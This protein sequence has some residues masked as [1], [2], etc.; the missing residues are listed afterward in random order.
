MRTRVALCVDDFGL[1]PCVNEAVVR[2]A[3]AGVVTT[4][5]CMSTGPAWASGAT[6]LQGA[7]RERL[8][9]GLHL[10][11][12]DPMPDGGGD[13]VMPLPELIVRSLLRTLPAQQLRQTI[14]HQLDRFE[15]G[16]GEPP[17]FIDGHQHVHQMP[18]IRDALM[19][20]IDAR[21]ATRGARW[22]PWLRLTAAPRGG[23]GPG[24][25]HRV[26]ESLGARE[27][28]RMARQRGLGLNRSLLGVYGFDEDAQSF[29]SR[30]V[31]WLAQAQDGDLLMLHPA[32]P[33]SDVASPS[34][35]HPQEGVVGDAIA[36][37]REVEYGV[38]A[39]EGRQ[40]LEQHD[41]LPV[42]LSRGSGI[43]DH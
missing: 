17:D 19:N 31:Q 20:A 3:D 27:L 39:R 29:R 33:T 5:G 42:R 38:L 23:S 35:G 37:A 11:L 13:L 16:F 34:Q 43:L 8:D 15:A 40:L 28:S 25:K 1:K 10:N 12:T 7:R 36:G 6:L 41:I 2:L 22:N 21:R 9:V 18:Q 26:I 24:F 4:V 14:E 32:V 30:L